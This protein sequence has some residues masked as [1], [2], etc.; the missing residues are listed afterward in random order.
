MSRSRE[1]SMLSVDGMDIIP[2]DPDK[3]YQP[4]KIGWYIG[5]L[6]AA[7]TG[8][9]SLSDLADVNPVYFQSIYLSQSGR[10]GQFVWNA[11]NLSSQV[12]SDP[13]QGLYVAPA[14]DVTGASGAWMRVV[15]G[16]VLATWWG[17]STGGSASSNN[18]ALSAALSLGSGRKVV[19]NIFGTIALSQNF[20]LTGKNGTVIEG[21][22]PG[23]TILNF[24]NATADLF[25][26]DTTA[27]D[28][29][30]IEISG[31]S[32]TSSVTRT[33]GWVINFTGGT[34]S[35][36]YPKNCKVHNIF[37]AKQFN[38][39]AVRKFL[40]ADIFDI[41]GE[42]WIGTG[43]RGFQAGQTTASPEN[44]GAELRLRNIQLRGG[45]GNAS[46]TPGLSFGFWLEGCEGVY[47]ENSCQAVSCKSSN[48]VLATNAG[49][50]VLSNIFLTSIVLDGTESDHCVKFT[51][52][53]QATRIEFAGSWWIASAGKLGATSNGSAGIYIPAAVQVDGLDL[54][55]GGRFFNNSNSAILDV[56]QNT[57]LACDG[58]SFQANGVANSAPQI[59]IDPPSVSTRGR[60]IANCRF[61][62]GSGRDISV[63]ANGRGEIINSNAAP[64]GIRHLGEPEKVVGN[65]TVEGDT[66]VLAT[67][68]PVRMTEGFYVVNGSGAF[69][70]LDPSYDGH[71]ICMLFTGVAT[72]SVGSGNFRLINGNLTTQAGTI[73]HAIYGVN[74]WWEISRGN[75]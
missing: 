11:G 43:G 73:V 26:L 35:G 42:D 66:L 74:G 7:A 58:V 45:T 63:T 36:F 47:M 67:S 64:L 38:G 23:V 4:G 44:Q 75:T 18:A 14:T 31:F 55:S 72:K 71:V 19:L 16:P 24:Q 53:G 28:A 49:G 25:S 61:S 52:S 50:H 40:F 30:N 48:M 46:L 22:G 10:E 33:A 13:L 57:G 20:D 6:D 56:A 39:I 9:A 41:Y 37:M 27:A 62:Q 70:S 69:A 65:S 17:L 51:G 3:V 12:T 21:M 1:Q 34:T 5:Q 32:V 68:I 8:I 54:S 2:Y 15:D 29:S 60:V 59:L